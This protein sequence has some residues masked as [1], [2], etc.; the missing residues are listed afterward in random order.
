MAQ[1]ERT[2]REQTT[3]VNGK[4]YPRFVVDYGRDADGKGVRRTFSTREGAEADIKKRTALLDAMGRQAKRANRPR[5]A[6]RR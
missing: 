2:I 1:T 3:T 5:T 4:Q 6:R